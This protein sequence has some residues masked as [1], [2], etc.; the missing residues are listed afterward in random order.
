MKAHHSNG[1]AALG[2]SRLAHGGLYPPGMAP[3]TK[4]DSP[5]GHLVR[6]KPSGEGEEKR[7]ER[8]Q[9]R[10][11]EPGTVGSAQGQERREDKGREDDSSDKERCC[12]GGEERDGE[13]GKSCCCQGQHLPGLLQNRKPVK[14]SMKRKSPRIKLLGNSEFYIHPF[15]WRF[16]P[17][18]AC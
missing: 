17:G 11:G 4:Q 15:P 5:L 12:G 6:E 8:E 13:V 7:E 10:G 18:L 14:C 16:A 3:M 1:N 9:E 2:T